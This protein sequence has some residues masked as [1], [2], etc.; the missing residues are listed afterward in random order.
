M[1]ICTYDGYFERC[2]LGRI[3]ESFGEH[4]FIRSISGSDGKCFQGTD[5]SNPSSI[6]ACAKHFSLQTVE[7]GRDY[8]TTNI[9]QRQ[10]RNVYLPPFEQVIREANCA[11]VM[12][13]MQMMVF[14]RG[15]E[16][17]LRTYCVRNGILMVL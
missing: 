14:P 4:L 5:L 8:N 11:T 2:P 16:Y 17:L 1:D 13:L 6:A 10:L 9:P 7:G 12:T 15:N 3:A